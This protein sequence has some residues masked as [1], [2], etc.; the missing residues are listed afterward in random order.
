MGVRLLDHGRVLYGGAPPRFLK[1]DR[2]GRSAAL[3]LLRNV[4][5][6][7]E[8]ASEARSELRRRLI[9]AGMLPPTPP[10]PKKPLPS[11]AVVIPHYNDPVRAA[12]TAMMLHTSNHDTVTTA[13]S[14]RGSAIVVVD[15]GSDLDERLTLHRL[16]DDLSP[17]ITIVDQPTNR[18]PAAARNL[19][20][21]SVDPEVVVF[22]DSGVTMRSETLHKLVAW[23][24]DPSISASAPRVRSTPDHGTDRPVRRARFAP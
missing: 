22:V 11:Y 21:A 5:N 3:A 18:G 23:L 2:A 24:D 1:L 16:L 6:D 7:P 19:G 8:P 12:A 4:V 9:V 14:G 10:D 15:D 20:A 13:V 17:A